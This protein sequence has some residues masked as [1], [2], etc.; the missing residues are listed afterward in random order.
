MKELVGTTIYAATVEKNSEIL[1]TVLEWYIDNKAKVSR[2]CF[3]CHKKYLDFWDPP[4][5]KKK[6]S[7]NFTNGVFGIKIG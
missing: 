4:T 3:G 6:K 2:V 1:R 5:N 7:D